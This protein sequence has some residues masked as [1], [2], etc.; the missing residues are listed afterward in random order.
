MKLGFQKWFSILGLLAAIII[1]LV[2]GLTFDLSI[3]EGA[4]TMAP[5]E[6]IGTDEEV[7]AYMTSPDDEDATE[8]ITVGDTMP[9]LSLTDATDSNLSMIRTPGT[10]D[11]DNFTNNRTIESFSLIQN[12]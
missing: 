1:S 9:D 10:D 7:K 4:E 5:E 12:F 2:I 6:E 11:S 3:L 8:E